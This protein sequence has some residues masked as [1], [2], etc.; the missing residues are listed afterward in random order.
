MA[1]LN[2]LYIK[3]ETLKTILDTLNKKGEKGIEL[4]VSLNDESNN[5]GQNISAYVAQSKEQREKKVDKF[6]VGNGK[7]F[8]TKGETPIAKK[9]EASAP[10]QTSNE[11]PSDLPF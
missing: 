11:E 2:S 7:T 3:T 10:A 8:W 1:S 9:Q 4:T 5:Y 6:Y